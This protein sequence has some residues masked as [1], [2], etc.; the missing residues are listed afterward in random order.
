[1]HRKSVIYNIGYDRHM[2]LN[3]VRI[4]ILPDVSVMYW[5]HRSIVV[6]DKPTAFKIGMPELIN[7]LLVGSILIYTIQDAQR[8][9]FLMKKE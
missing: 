1:M 5:V 9:I 6:I 7:F 4:Y 8:N 3:L 2:R